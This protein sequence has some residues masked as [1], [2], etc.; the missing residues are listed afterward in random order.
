MDPIAN[1]EVNVTD[2][3]VVGFTLGCTWALGKFSTAFQDK[4]RPYLPLVALILGVL[5][6]SVMDAMEGEP[7]T[8]ESLFRGLAAGA[9]AVMSHQQVHQIAKAK[10]Q[11]APEE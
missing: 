4:L 9:M 6:R 11:G 3:I 8:V 10:D 7:L 5:I 1:P 2:P